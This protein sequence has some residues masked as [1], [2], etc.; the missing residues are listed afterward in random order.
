MTHKI[1]HTLYIKDVIFYSFFYE[2]KFVIL[3]SNCKIWNLLTIGNISAV[4]FATIFPTFWILRG[5][6]T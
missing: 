2:L 1:S 4:S 6:I 3:N 5:Q